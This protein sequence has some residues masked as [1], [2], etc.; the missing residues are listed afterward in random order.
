MPTQNT[1]VIFGIAMTAMSR[2]EV[3]AKPKSLFRQTLIMTETVGLV[4]RTIT[5]LARCVDGSLQTPILDITVMSFIA[6]PGSKK[7]ETD[8]SK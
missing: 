4:T 1:T 8:A 3:S 6:M 7:R 5:R 2:K